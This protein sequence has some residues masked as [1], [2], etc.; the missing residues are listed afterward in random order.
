MRLM[1]SAFLQ[2]CPDRPVL[3]LRMHR[4]LGMGNALVFQPC[5]QLGQTLYAGLG[6]EQPVAHI[7]RLVLNLPLLLARGRRA[8]AGVGNPAASKHPAEPL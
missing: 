8:G 5:I 3:E 6:Q 2:H 1:A 4:G 7:A